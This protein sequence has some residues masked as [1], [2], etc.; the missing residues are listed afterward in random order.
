MT[1][2]LATIPTSEI[3]IMARVMGPLFKKKPEDMF[4]LM[5]IAQAEGK[6]PAIAAQEYDIIEGRPSINSRSTLARFQGSGGRIEYVERT[7]SKCTINFEHPQG[8]KLTITWTIERAQKAGLNGKDNWRKYPAQMLA[9]RAIAEGVRALYPACLS[10]LYT[11]EEVQDFE[12]INVTPP[13]G[14]AVETVQEQTTEPDPQTEPQ[15]EQPQKIDVTKSNEWASLMEYLA[16]TAKPLTDP[17][18]W[19]KDE[20]EAVGHAAILKTAKETGDIRLVNL[21]RSRAE[22]YTQVRDT[23]F[24]IMGF[25]IIRKSERTIEALPDLVEQ[26]KNLLM[27]NAQPEQ[28][29]EQHNAQL[30]IF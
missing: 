18:G 8:G 3:Q 29:D 7:D 21:A 19:T 9:A 30:D 10:G 15:P 24:Q 26:I 23:E 1:Q 27:S 6:H 2:A 17:K 12:P 13:K 14:E 4:A 28:A 22:L 16:T 5:L 20:R 25:E 11:S